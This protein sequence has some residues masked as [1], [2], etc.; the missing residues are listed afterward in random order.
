M[1]KYYLIKRDSRYY[2]FNNE[3]S[4]IVRSPIHCFD[5]DKIVMPN[6]KR[7]ADG[8]LSL[9][10]YIYLHVEQ[11]GSRTIVYPSHEIYDYL[12]AKRPPIVF[13]QSPKSENARRLK[14][15]ICQNLNTYAPS[16]LW[17]IDRY[18]AGAFDNTD[19]A[20]YRLAAIAGESLLPDESETVEYKSCE[21]ELN[22]PEILSSIGA[23]ANHKGG[24][25]TLGVSDNKSIVGCEKLISKYSSMDKFSVMLR[26]FVKQGTNTNIYLNIR[27]EFE[28]VGSHTLCHLHIPESP[29]IVLVKDEQLYV[30]SGATSQRLLGDRMIDFIYNRKRYE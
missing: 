1:D 30:R 4:E 3:N 23:F 17:E 28:Q 8:Y 11:R 21:D 25:L 13:A 26:N 15:R 20:I 16:T 5:A 19:A 9:G 2:Y 7:D 6:H 27:I 14:Q 24:T 10:Q 29:D 18:I 22:K 12:P